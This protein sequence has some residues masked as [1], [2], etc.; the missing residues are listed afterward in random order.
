[1]EQVVLRKSTVEKKGE[2]DIIV[3]G[4]GPAGCAAAFAA[5]KE[6]RRVLLIE[7][8]GCLGGMA[9]AGGHAHISFYAEYGTQA[10]R[11]VG[12]FAHDLALKGVREGW[13]EFDNVTFDFESEELKIALE[14]ELTGVGVTLLY[15]SEFIE[16]VMHE[17]T[18]RGVVI[19]N[20]NG[21][22]FYAAQVVIDCT[23]D[24][25]VAASAGAEFSVGRNGDHA[26]QPVTLMFTVDQIDW[27]KICAWRTDYHMQHVFRKAREN[28]DLGDFQSV[29]HGFWHTRSRPDMLGINFTN[30]VKVD[31]LDAVELTRATLE[32]REQVRQ[33]IEVFRKYV[34]GMENARLISTAEYLGVRETRR[35]TGDYILSTDDLMKMRSFPDTI[36]Y[37]S[38][39]FDVHGIDADGMD[40]SA[41][42]PQSGFHY[43]IPYRILLPA[44][45][46]QILVAGRCVSASHLAQ[47]SLRVMA[48]CMLMG[49]AAGI[50]AALALKSGCSPRDIDV[51]ELQKHLHRHGAI[52]SEDEIVDC[53]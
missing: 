8:S 30:K 11:C 32:C 3:V 7:R 23:G 25:D 52:L 38:F 21:L 19:H 49:E 41:V 6:G 45:L 12:G 47:S 39:L 37:G 53:R 15:F 40:S 22:Q 42:C 5:A 35:I 29:I 27:P 33:S 43:Q 18:V 13:G 2:F 50:A 1:M 31:G 28:G 14:R 20:K 24:G 17:S 26:C 10:M 48:T 46:N 4:G 16:S 9:T 36:G 51:P 34:P 44:G